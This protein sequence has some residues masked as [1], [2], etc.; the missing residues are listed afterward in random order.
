MNDAGYQEKQ[1]GLQTH[2]LSE[3]TKNFLGLKYGDSL[4]LSL[5]FF[6]T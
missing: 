2:R 3:I 4:R 5:N 6:L 1:T